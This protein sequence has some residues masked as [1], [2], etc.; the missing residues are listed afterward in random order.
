MGDR[1]Q[2]LRAGFA[3]DL[4]IVLG[5]PKPEGRAVRNNCDEV[6]REAERPQRAG[7]RNSARSSAKR[8]EAEKREPPLTKSDLSLALHW[9]LKA[10]LRLECLPCSDSSNQ[11]GRHGDL[12]AS[13]EWKRKGVK[14]VCRPESAIWCRCH[15]RRPGLQLGRQVR[16]SGVAASNPSAFCSWIASKVREGKTAWPPISSTRVVVKA[17]LCNAC[18]SGSRPTFVSLAA[19]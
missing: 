8:M 7:R 4:E 9:M 16:L 14:I 3:R 1:N 17:A 5:V 10:R 13:R 12:R 15:D 2:F 11:F 19:K 6:K 18:R